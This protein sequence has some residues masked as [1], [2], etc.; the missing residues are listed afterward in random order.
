MDAT[1][2]STT[3]SIAKPFLE[4]PTCHIQSYYYIEIR[5]SSAMR[6]TQGIVSSLQWHKLQVTVEG[7][8][9]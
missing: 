9:I 3:I 2:L 7:I 6:Q 5:K 1:W 8:T 4:Q